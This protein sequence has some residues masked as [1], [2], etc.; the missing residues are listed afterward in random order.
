L[1]FAKENI[2][3]RRGTYRV[4]ALVNI[5]FLNITKPLIAKTY[6]EGHTMTRQKQNKS[7]L[8]RQKLSYYN[9]NTTKDLVQHT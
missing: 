5:H 2:Y 3:K 4:N 8:L 6:Y 9:D 7:K 1:K